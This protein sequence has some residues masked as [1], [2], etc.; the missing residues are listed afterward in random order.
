MLKVYAP[1][2]GGMALIWKISRKWILSGV[3]SLYV[4]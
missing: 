4:N 2:I 3:A 1:S